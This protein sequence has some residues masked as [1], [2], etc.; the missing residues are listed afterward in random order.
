MHFSA[1]VDILIQAAASTTTGSLSKVEFLNNGSKIG[2]SL[3]APYSMVWSNVP[4]GTYTLNARA[5]NSE[6]DVGV[7]AGVHVV[8]IGPLAQI[9]VTPADIVTAPLGT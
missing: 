2:E 3:E 1:P 4:P 6:G 9:H 8:V 5:T 7:S